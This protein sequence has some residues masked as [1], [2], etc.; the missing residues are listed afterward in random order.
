MDFYYQPGRRC[1]VLSCGGTASMRSGLCRSHVLRR[2]YFGHEEARAPG[3]KA[4]MQYLREA[5]R[6]LQ[7]YSNRKATTAALELAGKV[8][9]YQP[10]YE[11]TVYTRAA[12]E[13]ERLGARA[14]P[15]EILERVVAAYIAIDSDSWHLPDGRAEHQYLGRVVLGELWHR[16]EG[17][18][19]YL[20]AGR[21]VSEIG[22][23]VGRLLSPYA[24]TLIRRSA[25]DAAGRIGGGTSA[26][27]S[28][29]VTGYRVT[30]TDGTLSQTHT[31][32]AENFMANVAGYASP[33]TVEVAAMNKYTGAGPVVQTVA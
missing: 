33:V 4:R 5:R 6:L 2:R 28:R 32:T 20:L 27:H 16:G 24:R 3:R 11:F 9:D 14:S 23:H 1:R 15:G 21:V 17:G 29:Y 18:R 22:S 25:A 19:R 10:A 31:V 7:Q 8:P 30:I 26:K 12:Y 13:L